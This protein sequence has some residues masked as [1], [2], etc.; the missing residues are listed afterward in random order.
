VRGKVTLA[1]FGPL[2][3]PRAHLLQGLRAIF[4]YAAGDEAA[5]ETARREYLLLTPGG[6]RAQL[7]RHGT[8][9]GYAEAHPCHRDGVRVVI[10]G[11]ER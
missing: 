1:G 5:V 6:G 2:K 11:R 8:V 7:V 3:P 9:I 4:V 10:G